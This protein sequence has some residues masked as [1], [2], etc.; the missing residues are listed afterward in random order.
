MTR[1]FRNTWMER[2]SQ[3]IYG[4]NGPG[5]GIPVKLLVLPFDAY[6]V[7]DYFDS[8]H[9]GNPYGKEWKFYRPWPVDVPKQGPTSEYADVWKKAFKAFQDHF[10]AHPQ[11]NR[12]ALIV[13]LLSLGRIYDDA[14]I[15]KMLYYGKLLKD[16]G[17]RRLK[18]RVDGWY[19][20][21]TM[22]RMAGYVDIAIL[23]LGEYVPEKV[24]NY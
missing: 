20:P 6:P 22:K 10:D 13:F 21:E 5:Y 18:Y 1:A 17:A 3:R 16:S 12:T 14:S 9:V 15:E 4:Y 8:R 2:H 23:G 24:E 7:N 11:W 19:P